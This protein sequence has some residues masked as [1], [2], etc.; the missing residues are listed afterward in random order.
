MSD[1]YYGDSCWGSG[2]INSSINTNSS[3]GNSS[4]S[5]STNN[6]NSSVDD[7]NYKS[8][9]IALKQTSGKSTGRTELK[10][11]F[12]SCFTEK[13]Q[14]DGY[15]NFEIVFLDMLQFIRGYANKSLLSFV[16]ETKYIIESYLK[17]GSCKYFV[18]CFDNYKFVPITKYPEQQKRTIHT[19]IAKY[20]N[21]FVIDC[22][23]EKNNWESF[24]FPWELKEIQKTYLPYDYDDGLQD[25]EGFRFFLI[26]WLVYQWLACFDEEYRIKVPMGTFVIINGHNLTI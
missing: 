7:N 10:R 11:R 19:K 15:D 17:G 13:A 18:V 2:I 1:N 20:D 9:E 8:T 14:Y 4:S 12:P 23:D 26:Q 25:R 5:S 16:K 24:K 3:S 6:N 22:A 21:Q